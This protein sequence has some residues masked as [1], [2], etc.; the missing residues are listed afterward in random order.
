MLVRNKRTGV[1]SVLSDHL[2]RSLI[3][4][5]KVE[6]VKPV[7]Q[8]KTIFQPSEKPA[9][10]SKAKRQKYKTKDIQAEDK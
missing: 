9:A 1:E 6:Q 10:E 5:G 2:A 7:R 4:L 3:D 8:A